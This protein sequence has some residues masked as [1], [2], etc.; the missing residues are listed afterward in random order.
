[1]LSS[2]NYVVMDVPGLCGEP[3]PVRAACRA[4]R[5]RGAVIL[6]SVP[7]GADAV[8]LPRRHRY[9][10]R[11]L[12]RAALLDIDLSGGTSRRTS[13]RSS[14][15]P[16]SDHWKAFCGAWVRC[17]STFRSGASRPTA[18]RRPRV[19]RQADELP[20][21][22]T[23]WRS[24]RASPPVDVSSFIKSGGVEST[25]G[26]CSPWRSPRRRPR[27]ALV[28]PPLFRH[29]GPATAAAAPWR[30][31]TASAR[32]G[33][34]PPRRGPSRRC[35]SAQGGRPAGQPCLP[36]HRHPR[37]LHDAARV[38]D[39]VRDPWRSG[40]PGRARCCRGSL[41]TAAASTPSPPSSRKAR[42]ARSPRR[43]GFV[44]PPQATFEL[45]AP[46]SRTSAAPGAAPNR[47][48]PAAH[49]DLDIDPEPAA[50]RSRRARRG[51]GGD[52]VHERAIGLVRAGRLKRPA[53]GGSRGRRRGARLWHRPRPGWRIL[54][55]LGMIERGSAM[56]RRPSRITSGQSAARA[57]GALGSARHRAR[58]PRP[59]SQQQKNIEGAF[60]ATSRAVEVL[61]AVLGPTHL[62]VRYAINNAGPAVG[63][64]ATG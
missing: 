64:Q 42:P 48:Q 36:L 8:P 29:S 16:S 61:T 51:P 26:Y 24:S 19:R 5:Y 4:G 59:H 25:C 57:A 41:P 45:A 7:A 56:R 30:T 35:R 1:M 3:L 54:I 14:T 47:R 12:L 34:A 13:S 33:T 11:S 28:R 9:Y 53:G 32:P 15:A 63:R 6:I 23:R 27:R 50:H 49:D 58:Q 40:S 43:P 18:T 46:I 37:G 55:N 31:G 62:H 17:R 38:P 10:C 21:R 44:T 22:P 2:P 39:R 60:A 20:A 52:A